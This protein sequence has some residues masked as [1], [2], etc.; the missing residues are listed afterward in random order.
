MIKFFYNLPVVFILKFKQQKFFLISLDVIR[1]TSLPQKIN[2]RRNLFI[3]I[4]NASI[5]LKNTSGTLAQ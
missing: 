2:S 3:H 1:K 5:R 4:F